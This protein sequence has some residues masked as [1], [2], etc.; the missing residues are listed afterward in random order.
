MEGP[1]PAEYELRPKTPHPPP[2]QV[3]DRFPLLAASVQRLDS[4]FADDAAWLG[5]LARAGF[6]PRAKTIWVRSRVCV[7]GCIIYGW[8]DVLCLGARGPT[9]SH[10]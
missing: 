3:A 6:D 7:P 4:N 8:I 5:K 2:R 9:A 10:A 1:S